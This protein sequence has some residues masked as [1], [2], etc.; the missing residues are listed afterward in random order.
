MRIVSL[1][2]SN[3]EILYALGLGKHVVGVTRFCDRPADAKKKEN[4]GG[5]LDIDVDKIDSLQPDI[6]FTSTFLQDKIAETLAKRGYN[7]VHPD[8]K[9]LKDVYDSI[10]AIGAMTG[11][12]RRSERLVQRMKEGFEEI[13]K[14]VLGKKRVAVYCEEWHKPPT[15]SGNWVPEIVEIAGG[16]S[17]AR[18]GEI[19]YPVKAEHV[20]NFRPEK[21][22]VSW[23]GFG[24][25]VPL[26]WIRKRK[27][28][29][30]IP[31]VK[32]S[33]IYILDD[34]L[35]NR[36]GPRLVEAAKETSKI[37]HSKQQ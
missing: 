28:W 21:I 35:L 16:K 23:C 31:A 34:S 33:E 6:I 27:G 32:N 22:I 36:P 17:L 10:L 19:S 5:L 13:R 18:P 14:S 25:K 24:K 3:T 15:V 30:R 20:V 12:Q 37:L 7:V 1:A 8:P 29:E 9:T 11:K 26:E 2:P 4:V